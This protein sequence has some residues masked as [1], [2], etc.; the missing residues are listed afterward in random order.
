MDDGFL[1]IGPF[2]RAS[3]L[4]IKALR[5]YHEAG[6]LVPARVDPRTGYRVYDVAQLADAG[7]VRQLRQLDLPL[8][9]IRHILTARDPAVTR[10]ILAE[11]E[12]V[13]RNRLAA[14]ERIV[15]ELQSGVAE[16]GRHTP[17]H[18]RD[19]PARHVLALAGDC[20]EAEFAAFLGQAYP[21]LDA[22]AAAAGAV[23]AGPNGALYPP[24]VPDDVSPVVAYLPLAEPVALPE[25][26]AGVTLGEVP[27]ARVAV[28]VHAGPYETLDGAYR[29]LGAWV[30]RFAQP[31]GEWVREVYLTDPSTTSDPAD[32][33]T[34]ICWP[35]TI[36]PPS[37]EHTS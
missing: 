13:M 17:V 6:V 30:A 19:D 7:V 1:T 15:A 20:R 14:T 12:A 8:T 26:T 21:T 16:P 32:Y 25:Q 36:N 23:P 27:A 10:T 4:S 33:R 31:S 37:K 34:E 18:V 5:A 24:S 22:V 2:S 11:H 9:Q 29:M 3:L 35:I 28:L